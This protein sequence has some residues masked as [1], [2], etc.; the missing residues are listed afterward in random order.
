MDE[1]IRP[2]QPAFGAISGPPPDDADYV[3]LVEKT[4]LR[5]CE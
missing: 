3:A 5:G 1:K 2:R 4:L